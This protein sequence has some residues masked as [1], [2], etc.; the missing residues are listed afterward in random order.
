MRPKQGRRPRPQGSGSAYAR[1]TS[2]NLDS[3]SEA[4][5]AVLRTLW[6]QR[7]TPMASATAIKRA[8]IEHAQSV[9]PKAYAESLAEVRAQRER[10]AA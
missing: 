9:A 7:R 6:G 3:A 8:L 10:D 2:L 5:L 4:A 1:R